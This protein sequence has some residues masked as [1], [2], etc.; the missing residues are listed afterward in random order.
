M[1]K[2]KETTN[3]VNLRK[4]Q[5][6][7]LNEMNTSEIN[8]QTHVRDVIVYDKNIRYPASIEKNDEKAKFSMLG[9]NDV[10]YAVHP[11]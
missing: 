5:N 10:G 7:S 8:R 6:V 4:R 9:R 3:C 1:C 2:L 11:G